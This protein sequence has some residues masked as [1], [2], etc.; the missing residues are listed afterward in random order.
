MKLENIHFETDVYGHFKLNLFY[1]PTF[2]GDKSVIME[3]ISE[4][5]GKYK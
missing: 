1:E 2:L 5:S 3:L 4:E